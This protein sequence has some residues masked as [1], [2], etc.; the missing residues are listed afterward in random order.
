MAG[1]R[2]RL[3]RRQQPRSAGTDDDHIPVIKHI[4]PGSFACREARAA[5]RGQSSANGQLP[6]RLSRQL[7]TEFVELQVVQVAIQLAS[8]EQLEVRSFVDQ[9][10]VVEDEDAI[11]SAHGR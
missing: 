1:S 6:A 4:S 9:P 5:R 7:M 8:L 11:G 2:T 3:F 10:G